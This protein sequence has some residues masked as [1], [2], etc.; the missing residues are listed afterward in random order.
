MNDGVNG[1]MSEGVN[2]GVNEKVVWQKGVEVTKSVGPSNR[3]KRTSTSR[4]FEGHYP[5]NIFIAI[6]LCVICCHSTPGAPASGL[7]VGNVK[8]CGH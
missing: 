7:T 2:K 1:G 6:Q 4:C 8:A 5:D 3:Q